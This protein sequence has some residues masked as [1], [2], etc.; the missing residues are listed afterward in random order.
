MSPTSPTLTQTAQHKSSHIIAPPA[1]SNF[2]S[3]IDFIDIKKKFY[4]V[5]VR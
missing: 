4:K 2:L 1:T 5:L 3:E